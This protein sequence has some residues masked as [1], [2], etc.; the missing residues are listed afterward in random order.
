VNGWPEDNEGYFQGG[1]YHLKS[2]LPDYSVRVW[3]P[4]VPSLTDFS[5]EVTAEK[6]EGDDDWPFGIFFRDPGEGFFYWFAIRGDAV[7]LLIQHTEVD[8]FEA[9]TDPVRSAAINRGNGA[10]NRLKVVVQGSRIEMYVNDVFLRAVTDTSFPRGR[11]GLIVSSRVHAAY[12]NLVVREVGAAPGAPP[13]AAP[14]A[15]PPAAPAAPPAAAAPAPV[16]VPISQPV[17]AAVPAG[18]TRYR[19]AQYGFSIAVP[20]NWVIRDSGLPSAGGAQAAVQAVEPASGANVGVVVET[21][22][23]AMTLDAYFEEAIETARALAGFTD[24]ERGRLTIGGREARYVIVTLQSEGSS[25]T[26]MFDVLVDGR[27]AFTLG[28]TARSQDFPRFRAT[29]ETIGNS[30]LIE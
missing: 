13:A 5:Y 8:G 30:F 17:S 7:Y 10:P 14:V 21:L 27:R 22:P 20:A 29:F 3:A 26:L 11:F 19:N 4:G 28:F 24:L 18:Y 6:V 2:A 12:S 23:Q 25:F 1:R 9:L 16:A 15:A